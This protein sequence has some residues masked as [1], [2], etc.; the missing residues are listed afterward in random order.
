MAAMFVILALLPALLT[1]LCCAVLVPCLVWWHVSR[2][3]APLEGEAPTD[4]WALALEHELDSVPSHRRTPKA[5]AVRPWARLHVVA[6][7]MV[8]RPLALA[9]WV[10][11][12]M[13]LG[14]RGPPW[15]VGAMAP[16]HE[17]TGEFVAATWPLTMQNHWRGTSC[18]NTES[19]RN[20]ANYPGWESSMITG[21]YPLPPGDRL[22]GPT[23]FLEKF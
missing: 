11:G 5:R 3:E 12:P 20:S 6:A 1:V 4:G 23:H 14:A 8:E 10:L 21:R 18:A 17:T 2:A 19:L 15:P 7:P 22:G 16:T 13:G 9:P